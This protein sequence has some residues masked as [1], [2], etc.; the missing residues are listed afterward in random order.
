MEDDPQPTPLRTA[1]SDDRDQQPLRRGST[2]KVVLDDN[3]DESSQAGTNHE[4]SRGNSVAQSDEDVSEEDNDSAIMKDNV[5][6]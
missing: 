2:R 5:C 1:N 3:S 4:H 6:V